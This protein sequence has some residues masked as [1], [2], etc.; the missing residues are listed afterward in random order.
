M[1]SFRIA[2]AGGWAALAAGV[3][4]TVAAVVLIFLPPAVP[5]DVFSYPLTA[6]GHLVAQ[7]VFGVH[8]FVAAFALWAF[9]RAG[10]AGPG[11]FAA[12]SGI[13]SAAIFALFGVWEVVVGAFGNEPVPSP[14]V[15]AI[16]SVYGVLSLLNAVALVVFGIAAA[17]ARVLGTVSR[18]IVFIFGAF[19]IVPGL[20]L[21]FVSFV[22]GRVVIAVWLLLLA[23]LGIAMLRW[24][25]AEERASVA[26]REARVSA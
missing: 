24:A 19:L 15:D 8:H 23:W 11:R 5:E 9:W 17:R 7:V 18:W 6:E 25:A 22:A 3:F 26:G 10:L 1:E 12:V 2:R 20:P 16:D 14:T 13:A 21:L 4:G